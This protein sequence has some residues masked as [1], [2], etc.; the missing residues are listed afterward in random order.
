GSSVVPVSLALA[1][2]VVGVTSVVV[3]SV[4]VGSVALGSVAS[5]ASVP[6]ALVT[7]PSSP[8][9]GIVSRA[10][11]LERQ[12]RVREIRM[13]GTVQETRSPRLVPRRRSGAPGGQAAAGPGLARAGRPRYRL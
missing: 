11:R 13:S 10:I 4:V 3:P 9:A 1:V 8:Q 2:E 7:F 5:V 12:V 6:L